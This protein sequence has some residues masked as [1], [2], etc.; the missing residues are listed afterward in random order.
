MKTNEEYYSDPSQWG[1]SQYMSLKSIVD[2]YMNGLTP[3][4][5]T[6][7]ATRSM[8]RKK[9][10]NAIKDY[11]FSV[12]RE[13]ISLELDISTSLQVTLPLDYKDYCSISWVDS[14][15]IKY[16]MAKNNRLSVAQGILQDN[17]YQ[18]IYDNTGAFLTAAGRRPSADDS[19]ELLSGRHTDRG[20]TFVNGSFNIDKEAGII[21]FDSTALSK[22]IALDYIS[23][24]V[25]NKED[26][27]IKISAKCF[28]AIND[29]IYFKL[30]ERDMFVPQSEKDRARRAM[31]V[32]ENKL[33]GLLNP[34][35]LEDVLQVLKSRTRQVKQV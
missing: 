22:T 15:G 16:P 29:R 26:S 5:P 11:S 27:E 13:I 23:D 3:N 9:A 19:H 8:V 6:Y 25:Y 12:A 30:I 1:E 33:A 31:K 20:Q 14:K 18:F 2:D 35:R 7:N 34:V 17:D 4:D 21:Q 24:G 10:L 32:S 28:E